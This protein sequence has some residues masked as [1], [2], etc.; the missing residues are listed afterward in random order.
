MAPAD[1]STGVDGREHGAVRPQHET[2]RLEVA[3][4]VA[5]DDAEKVGNPLGIRAVG[6]GEGQ[7]SLG[8]QIGGGCFVVHGEG[9][10]LDALCLE[11]LLGPGV[12]GQL[13]V[14]TRAPGSPVD[15]D[16]AVAPGEV[17]GQGKASASD[18]R[19]LQ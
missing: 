14:A 9:G 13:R 10:H 11:C 17:V 2:S 18:Q 7:M 12:R 19:E 1:T 8:H 3:G 5:D 15:Q 4:L 16:Y 6:H